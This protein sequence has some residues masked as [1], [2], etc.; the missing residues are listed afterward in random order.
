MIFFCKF[1]I[2]LLFARLFKFTAFKFCPL[3]DVS[4]SKSKST[5]NGKEKFFAPFFSENVTSCLS[6]FSNKSMKHTAK[7]AFAK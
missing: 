2:G 3:S 4:I 7:I 5:K 6:V 1:L